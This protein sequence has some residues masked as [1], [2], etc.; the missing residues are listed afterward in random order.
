[1]LD[2]IPSFFQGENI[3]LALSD[4]ASIVVQLVMETDN[5]SVSYCDVMTLTLT[6]VKCTLPA[7]KGLD[8]IYIVI[9]CNFVNRLFKI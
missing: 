9:V 1:M 5:G 8:T 4:P 3:N 7:N 6:E 2:L